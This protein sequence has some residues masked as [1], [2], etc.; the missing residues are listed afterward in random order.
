MFPCKIGIN[1]KPFIHLFVFI[2]EGACTYLHR[3]YSTFIMEILG[4]DWLKL[5]Y[6]DSVGASVGVPKS[7]FFD[8]LAVH[9]INGCSTGLNT[10]CCTVREPEPG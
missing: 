1:N 3:S 6:F 7:S 5:K 8:F 10:R 9:K 4:F 2:I